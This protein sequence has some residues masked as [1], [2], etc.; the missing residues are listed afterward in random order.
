M[1]VPSVRF[2]STKAQATKQMAT[3]MHFIMPAHT[4]ERPQKYSRELVS[5]IGH[6]NLFWRICLNLSSFISGLLVGR[7]CL[8]IVI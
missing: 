4:I 6:E 8:T 1:N 2:N 3:Y 5:S 7:Y